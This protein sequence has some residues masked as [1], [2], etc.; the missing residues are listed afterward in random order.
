M[1]CYIRNIEINDFM[2]IF[3]QYIIHMKLLIVDIEKVMM[4]DNDTDVEI[5]EEEGS[6]NMSLMIDSLYN[7]IVCEKCGIELPFEWTMSHL[8]ENHGIKAQIVDV[9]RHLDLMRSSMKLTEAKEWIKN[10]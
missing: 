5:E 2:I 6:I 3:L 1:I 7:I 4:N 8:K 9:M 10:A